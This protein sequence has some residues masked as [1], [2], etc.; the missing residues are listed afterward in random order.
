M[1]GGRNQGSEYWDLEFD[2]NTHPGYDV[3][4]ANLPDVERQCLPTI[5]R[6]PLP[7]TGG[8]LD[9]SKVPDRCIT[10]F[11]SRLCIFGAR[12]TVYLDHFR[13]LGTG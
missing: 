10:A 3:S 11:A 2:W 4:A 5:N 8:Y 7:V 1:V 12:G 9:Y 13:A 6:H